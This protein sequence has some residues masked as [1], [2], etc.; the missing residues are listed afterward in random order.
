MAPL[1]AMLCGGA[2]TVLALI[3]LTQP[4]SLTYPLAYAQV[5]IGLIALLFFATAALSW[6]EARA[7]RA[8][9][10]AHVPSG[11]GG[12]VMTGT[13]LLCVLYAAS[14]TVVGYFPATATFVMAQLWLLGERRWWL[15]LLL[16]GG[17]TLLV[18]VVFD[19]LLLLP[20]PGG[21]LFGND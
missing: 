3:T 4:G 10:P 11:G 8:V 2:A 20:F 15:I 18:F 17:A 12:W 16:A 1:G 6:R 19:R 7:A 14:W 5:L 21:L 13:I 9:A